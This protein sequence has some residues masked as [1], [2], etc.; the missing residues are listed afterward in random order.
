MAWYWNSQKKVKREI[1]NIER[2]GKLPVYRVTFK[3]YGPC[4]GME[5]RDFN[6]LFE[7]DPMIKKAIKNY[8]DEEY[9]NVLIFSMEYAKKLKPHHREKQRFMVFNKDTL[10]MD[11]VPFAEFME[12]VK[13]R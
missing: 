7:E 10:K 11:F 13:R 6:L 12:I 1:H 2:L 3:G 9:D 8:A 4:G 5:V